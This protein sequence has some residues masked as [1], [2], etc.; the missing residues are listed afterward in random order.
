MSNYSTS[1]SRLLAN[2]RLLVLFSSL[3]LGLPPAVRA[4][5]TIGQLETV[6]SSV[7][8]VV[9]TLTGIATLVMLVVGG[10]KF[11]SASGDKEATQKAAK[12]LTYA[13]GG[14]VLTLSAWIILNFLGN[15]L[16]IDFSVFS[17]C[18]P[19]QTC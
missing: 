12:T 1:A 10:F 3:V 19:G 15:F 6:F 8:S 11:L 9:L 4:Q 18:L 17:I 16:G 2:R 14:L 7:V 13:I 5:A